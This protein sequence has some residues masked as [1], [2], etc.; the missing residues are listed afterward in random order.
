[1]TTVAR[2]MANYKSDLV[3]VEEVR[4]DMGGTEPAGE[5]KLFHGKGNENH[6]FETESF[7]HKRTY[8]QLRG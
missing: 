2:E 5:Y 4:R 8:Q 6:E 1:V 7:E 3:G